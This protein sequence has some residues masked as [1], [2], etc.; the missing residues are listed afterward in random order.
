MNQRGQLAVAKC[1][2]IH[3]IKAASDTGDQGTGQEWRW[4]LVRFRDWE[5]GKAKGRVGNVT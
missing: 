2:F 5:H 1:L 4:S 3:S